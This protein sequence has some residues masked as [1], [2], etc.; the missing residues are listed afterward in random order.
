MATC[1]FLLD[2]CDILTQT[3]TAVWYVVFTT[4]FSRVLNGQ[5]EP[6]KSYFR[7]AIILG[8]VTRVTSIMG[9]AMK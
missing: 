1:N 4:I 8:I 6:C 3:F 5:E 2:F 7:V 9:L